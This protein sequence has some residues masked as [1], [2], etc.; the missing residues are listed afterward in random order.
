M[1]TRLDPIPLPPPVDRR[2]AARAARKEAAESRLTPGAVAG[3]DP[4][5]RLDR[6]ALEAP[7]WPTLPASD[8]PNFTDARPVTIPP[9]FD[10]A[11]PAGWQQWP[12][13]R[14]PDPWRHTVLP[15]VERYLKGA[16]DGL[17]EFQAGQ[18]KRAFLSAQG[19]MGITKK[20]E[21]DLGWASPP[22]QKAISDAIESVSEIADKIWRIGYAEGLAK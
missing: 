7:G 21:F 11:P 13:W 3:T 9:D 22:N 8:A 20:I 17:R 10:A 15:N 1:V 6:V 19:Q 12:T 5:P 4:G 2:A 18:P 14:K 16:E